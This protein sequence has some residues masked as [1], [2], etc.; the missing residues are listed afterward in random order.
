MRHLVPPDFTASEEKIAA[1]RDSIEQEDLFALSLDYHAVPN[2]WT[3]NP[4]TLFLD[5]LTKDMGEGTTFE[6][7]SFHDFPQY[8]ICTEQAK[9]YTDGDTELAEQILEGHVALND[10]PKDIREKWHDRAQW[11]RSRVQDFRH[12]MSR[13]IE[14][15]ISREASL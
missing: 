1:E 2:D 8:R 11:V 7:Y 12:E 10:M 3:D 4:F 15:S 9:T 13:R 14:D 5:S 6:G